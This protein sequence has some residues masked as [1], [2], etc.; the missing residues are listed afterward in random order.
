MDLSKIVAIGGKAGLF[1]IIG[2]GKNNVLVESLLDGKRFAA[3]A[4]EKMSVL[5]EISIYTTGED[6]P[7]KEVFKNIREVMGETLDFDLKK[8]SNNEL[9]EKFELVVSDFSQESV[10]PSD[11]RKVFSWYQLLQQ[12]GL[13]DF[14]ETA[15]ETAGSEPSPEA[16]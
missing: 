2:Q 15:E 11:M 7:L 8:L 12:K 10:Y 4:H 13:L 6:K 1:Q 3:F 14:S 9:S 5:Q 16:Q